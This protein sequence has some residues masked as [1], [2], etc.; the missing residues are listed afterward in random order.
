M[1]KCPS[2]PRLSMDRGGTKA[3]IPESILFL[4]I[5][6]QSVDGG[7]WGSVL[8]LAIHGP[9]ADGVEGGQAE[10]LSWNPSCSWPSTD[11]SWMGG[12]TKAAEKLSWSPSYSRP[13][14]DH[15]WIERGTKAGGKVILES[16]LFL[17][18]HGQS[19]DG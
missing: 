1:E 19:V 11:N 14:T 9:S 13:S 4:A 18:I 2:Y 10:K 3:V 8:F 5:Y 17:A 6:G 12:G 7:G 15:P 16:V